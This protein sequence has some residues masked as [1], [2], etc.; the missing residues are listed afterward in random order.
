MLC[1]HHTVVTINRS[2]GGR[3][4][5]NPNSPRSR[6]SGQ[7]NL[8]KEGTHGVQKL[9]RRWTVKK[10]V[11]LKVMRRE[12]LYF[13]Q[14]P[15][16]NMASVKSI[17]PHCTPAPASNMLCSPLPKRCGVRKADAFFINIRLL[18]DPSCD[19]FQVRRGLQVHQ[20]LLGCAQCPHCSLY[21]AH[22]HSVP[23]MHHIDTPHSLPSVYTCG[24]GCS[25]RYVCV[26]PHTQACTRTSAHGQTPPSL[27]IAEAAATCTYT[28]ICPQHMLPTHR[29]L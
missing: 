27:D 7:D 8:V 22:V 23:H 11:F 9:V 25:H 16:Q 26:R 10:D 29:G 24:P 15:A 12:L 20:C 1:P 3:F 18:K 28:Q 13:R 14:G 2:H 4:K 17:E 6:T 21:Q 5:Y 19:A